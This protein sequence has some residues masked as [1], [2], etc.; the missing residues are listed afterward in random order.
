T[1]T[2]A[3]VRERLEVGGLT[4]TLGGLFLEEQRR[5]RALDGT[6]FRLNAVERELA[7]SRLRSITLRE[8]LRATPAPQQGEAG[9]EPALYE[10]RR[11][12]H[13]LASGL[14]Q[15]EEALT[16]QLRQAEMRLRAIAAVAAE[17]DQVLRETLLWWPS[18]VPVS[19]EWSNR[20]PEAV[21]ALLDPRSWQEIRT[22]LHAVTIGSPATSLLTLL[23][24][25]LL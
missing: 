1:Q 24:V 14:V 16:D 12:R 15:A 3:S 18:H 19:A 11:I 25:A 2:L 17:I 21:V 20:I 8:H 9:D 13:A 10:L 7:Q 23:A 5:L 22:A 4:E 6:T